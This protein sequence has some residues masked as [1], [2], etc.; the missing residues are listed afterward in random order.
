MTLCVAA[1]A[2]SPNTPRIVV[3]S[4]WRVETAI[5]GAQIQQKL[6]LIANESW[7]AL[8][9]ADDVGR[10]YEL[11][12]LCSHH[13]ANA[14]QINSQNVSAVVKGAVLIQKRSMIEEYVNK[15]L[16]I[17]YEYFL[18]NGK[19]QLPKIVFEQMIRD[20]A[21]MKLQCS[22]ILCTFIG[23]QPIVF[24]VGSDGS[25]TFQE[26][27][28]AIG[29]GVFIAHPAMFQRKHES[30][31]PLSHALYHVYEAMK[32][33]RI[34]PGVGDEFSISVICPKSK[35]GKLKLQSPTDRGMSY[36]ERQ[37]KKYGLK[38]F[39]RLPSPKPYLEDW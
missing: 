20:I 30:A 23:R 16:G 5:A 33:G 28:A 32:L 7:V 17:P 1:V 37:Y 11:T 13:F 6:A 14:E 9:S 12:T 4:D 21:R 27:F 35:D 34:A 38:E 19:T 26:H 3:A 36:L 22:L 25:V 15:R 29:S 18:T 2:G 10:A 8:F 31:L 24:E 39:F